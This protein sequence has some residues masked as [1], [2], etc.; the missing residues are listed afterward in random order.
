MSYKAIPF[1]IAILIA[2]GCSERDCYNLPANDLAEQFS[3]PSISY[4]P[5]AWWHWMGS[6]FSEEGIIRDLKAMKESGIAG[7]TV[8]N[9]AS[10]VQETHAPVENNP[11]PDR[12]YR[13][14]AYWKALE[15]AARTAQDLGLKIGLHNSPGYSTAGGPWVTEE[16]GMQKT[17]MSVTK[18]TGGQHVKTNLPI[19]EL[20]IYGGWGSPRNRATFYEDIAVMAVDEESL[21]TADLTGSMNADG[22]LEWDAPEGRWEILRIGHAPTMSNPHPLPDDII[23]KVLESDKMN[24]ESA[25]MHWDNVLGPLKEHLGKYFGKSF[26]HILID[27]YEAG[28]QDWGKDFRDVFMSMHGYDPIKAMAVSAVAPESRE[29][30]KYAEDKKATISRMFIDCA[31]KTACDKIHEAGLLMYWEPYEG[32]FDTAESCSIP[33][34]PMGEF[35]TGSDGRIDSTVVESS[36]KY[37][38]R[39]VG[40]EAFTGRPETSHYTE[41]PEFLKRSADGAFVSGAN[42]LFL[43]HWVHQPFDDRYQPGMGMGWWGTHFGRNQTWFEPGKEF[44]RYLT[45]CQMLLQQGELIEHRDNWL[46][47]RSDHA[48][49]FFAVNQTDEK[50]ETTI[51][52]EGCGFMPELWNP[53]T[54]EITYAA[55]SKDGKVS[56]ELGPGQ[57]VFVVFNHE[58]PHYK[59]VREAMIC[60]SRSVPVE[61]SW[62]ISFKPKVD[63]NFELK[64]QDLEDFSLSE[65][66]RVRYFSGTATYTKEIQLDKNDIGRGRKVMLDLGD[67]NDIVQVSV[68]GKEV[69]VLWY[70]PYRTDI[71]EYVRKGTNTLELAVTDNW[72]NR[73]IGD[74]QYE[75]DF[76][77]GQDRGESMGRAIKGFPDWFLKEDRPSS[78]RKCFVI[79]SYFRKDSPLQPAGLLGPVKLEIQEVQR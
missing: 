79:W 13:S 25:A 62:D 43:H 1:M 4:G 32:P 70:P 37:G 18:V 36:R 12:T 78:D 60:S 29:A 42:R 76:E 63:E 55:T 38:K 23:G 21:E 15:C 54:A 27:S 57:S 5:Y 72:A 61:G 7:A 17:V 40:A 31:W 77:W 75:P 35:W 52:F 11:W 56:V 8:F 64:D 74:E 48:D 53:Y 9:I 34:L 65:D 41:D 19:P 73:L 47:R 26:T 14:E 59:K 24:S 68:N 10:A 39:I 16:T 67:L 6:N 22:S 46:H 3:Q 51:D 58:K 44:F 28:R 20:P 50:T 71:S 33:D 2:A 66:N 69:G 30:E 49:I 45:R